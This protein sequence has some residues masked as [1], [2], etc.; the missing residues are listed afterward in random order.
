MIDK[1]K[2]RAFDLIRAQQAM[3]A[4]LQGLTREIARLEAE[5]E[6]AEAEA[7][8][9]S[10]AEPAPKPIDGAPVGPGPAVPVIPTPGDNP[11]GN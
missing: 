9:K 1:H 5:T 7:L 10:K 3:A 4:E 6:K 2:A 11:E 8:A